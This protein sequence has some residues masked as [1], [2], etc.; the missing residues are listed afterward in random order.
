MAEPQPEDVNAALKPRCKQTAT[1]PVGTLV[2]D[3]EEDHTAPCTVTIPTHWGWGSTMEPETISRENSP[4][5]YGW[6][7][8]LEELG[9]DG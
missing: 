8:T 4:G 9:R 5:V 7:D 2:C 1:F 3:L 6:L